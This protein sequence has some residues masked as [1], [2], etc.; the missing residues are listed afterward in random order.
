MKTLFRNPLSLALLFSFFLLSCGGEAGDPSNAGSSSANKENPKPAKTENP[1]PEATK[2]ESSQPLVNPDQVM[3]TNASGMRLRD[4]PSQNGKVLESLAPGTLLLFAGEKSEKTEKITVSGETYNSH[5]LRVQTPQGKTGWIFGGDNPAGGGLIEWIVDAGWAK[6][7][8]GGS[9]EMKT[10]HKK[11]S[12]E[13]E[14]MFGIKGVKSASAGYSGVYYEKGGKKNGRL[15]FGASLGKASDER[16]LFFGNF[17]QNRKTGGWMMEL[18]QGEKKGRL[19]MSYDGIADH[20]LNREYT[21]WT[22]GKQTLTYSEAYSNTASICTFDEST[23]EID[24]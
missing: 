21:E 7:A 12:S 9:L 23:I 18:Y 19:S 20:C 3:I 1:K 6:S 17:E 14:K 8:Q 10:F 11:R 22:N 13:V 5:W 2:K 15:V 4:K 16:I 24:Y